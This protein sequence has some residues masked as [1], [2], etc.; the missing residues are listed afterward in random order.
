MAHADLEARLGF[1]EKFG[2][3]QKLGIF[4]KGSFEKDNN[5]RIGEEI[6]G[7]ERCNFRKWDFVLGFWR[8]AFKV[9]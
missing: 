1:F 9:I 7:V 5:N 2:N 6:I 4:R 8:I 3:F